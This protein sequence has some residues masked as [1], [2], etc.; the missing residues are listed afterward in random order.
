MG[1][2][3]LSGYQVLD[4]LTGKPIANIFNLRHGR[5]EN[6]QISANGRW[7]IADVSCVDVGVWDLK[8]PKK[9]KLS[10]YPVHFKHWLEFPFKPYL[11]KTTISQDG[12]M[13]AVTT[14]T[15]LFLFETASG[16]RTAHFK[17]LGGSPLEPSFSPDGSK[18]AVG[19]DNGTILI[20]SAYPRQPSDL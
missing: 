4:A 9:D 16:K 3:V 14:R 6:A 15:S 1:T 5:M 10:R 2:G 8:A 20:F 12:T 7:F 13:I 18:V 17:K 19:M 11:Q